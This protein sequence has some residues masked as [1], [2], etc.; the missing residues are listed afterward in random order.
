M[1]PETRL[2]PLLPLRDIVVFPHMMVPLYVGRS[3]SINAV[4]EAMRG[5]RELLLA[6]QKKAKTNEPAPEDIFSVGTISQLMQHIRRPDGTVKVLVEGRRRCRVLRYLPNEPF[7]LVEVEEFAEAPELHPEMEA[8][9]RTVHEVFDNYARLSRRLQPDVLMSIKSI[10][11]PARLSDTIVAHLPIKHGDKQAMLE[12][13]SARDRLEKLYELMQAEIEILQVERKIR[14]RV[15]KQMERTEKEYDLNEQMR[16]IQ[17][18]LGERDEFK[19]EIAEIEEKLKAKK[20]PDD[21]RGKIEKEIKKLKLMSPMSAEATVVRNYIDWCLALP[22]GEYSDDSLD[23]VEAE[24][25][26][27]E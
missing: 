7:F 4:E 26:L 27:E 13:A 10:E 3:K 23:I 25:I 21:A 8:L 6:A 17:K 5:N 1:K 12:M 20:M 19:N 15:K 9:L 18:E 24:R 22:W 16:A 2:L 14:S 11:E